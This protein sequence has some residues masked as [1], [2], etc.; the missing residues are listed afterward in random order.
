MESTEEI[1][2]REIQS[3]ELTGDWDCHLGIAYHGENGPVYWIRNELS[4]VED[5]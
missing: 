4:E 3:I 2:E 1:G 5:Q